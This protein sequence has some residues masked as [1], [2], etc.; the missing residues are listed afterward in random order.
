MEPFC[1]VHHFPALQKKYIYKLTFVNEWRFAGV[2]YWVPR[3]VAS[4]A[5]VSDGMTVA[6]CQ[7]SFNTNGVQDMRSLFPQCSGVRVSCVRL[8]LVSP[9]LT[10]VCNVSTPSLLTTYSDSS[11]SPMVISEGGNVMLWGECNVKHGA[12]PTCGCHLVYSDCIYTQLH[13]RE[14]E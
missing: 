9:R 11:L 8:C 5:H 1:D 6:M 7:Y 10:V 2:E 12:H 13:R 4:P 14:F 3:S